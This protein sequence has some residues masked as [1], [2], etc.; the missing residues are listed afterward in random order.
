MSRNHAHTDMRVS[1][2]TVKMIW[3]TF[4]TVLLLCISCIFED[5]RVLVL[6][7]KTVTNWQWHRLYTLITP[8]LLGSSWVAR[9]AVNLRQK[10]ESGC[11]AI[12]GREKFM[13]LLRKVIAVSHVIVVKGFVVG[14]VSELAHGF[15]D[16]LLTI[17]NPYPLVWWWCP[18]VNANTWVPH[19]ALWGGYV[20]SP[21]LWREWS[22]ELIFELTTW[23]I[24]FKGWNT[25]VGGTQLLLQSKGSGSVG[26]KSKK[27]SPRRRRSSNRS[28]NFGCIWTSFHSK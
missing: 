23:I 1:S 17:L 19:V 21:V 4:Y 6:F 11:S 12:C 15:V 28:S 7:V 2:W 14:T 9:F 27:N 16:V 10:V 26:D 22:D 8:D 25:I 18:C 3:P 20:T 24:G 13:S 5:I